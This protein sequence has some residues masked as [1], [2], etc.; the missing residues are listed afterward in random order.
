[1]ACIVQWLRSPLPRAAVL[2]LTA[3]GVAACSG[4]TRFDDN[5]FSS[6]NNPEA[7]GSI[8]PGAAA[9]IN[10]VESRPLPP[11]TAQL[12]SPAPTMGAPAS[13]GV[14]GGG[15]GMAS[16]SP[17]SSPARL[18]ASPAPEVTGAITTSK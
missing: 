17:N 13:A 14:S 8:Q 3:I 15:K 9:P 7:T 16:Y 2:A 1:M 11:Q 5:P 4:E 12:P 6:K 10:R 18:G